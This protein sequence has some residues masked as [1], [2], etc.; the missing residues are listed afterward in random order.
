MKQIKST[1]KDVF[2]I[3]TLIFLLFSIIGWMFLKKFPEYHLFRISGYDPFLPNL[4][5]EPIKAAM[6]TIRHPLLG[7]Y[8][9]PFYI[10]YN[11]F[12]SDIIILLLLSF[13][14]ATSFILIYKIGYEIVQIN[15]FESLFYP[16]C[17]FL[18]LIY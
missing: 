5:K 12:H 15:K 2:F 16:Y 13:M 8:M 14:G 9:L 4:I 1:K 6:A 3:F 10:L 18:L 17:F 11:I 7:V